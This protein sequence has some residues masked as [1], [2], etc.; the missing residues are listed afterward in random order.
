M[1]HSMLC[2]QM[3]W[4]SELIFVRQCEI[5]RQETCLE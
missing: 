4:Y 1:W 2:G 5:R 3:R